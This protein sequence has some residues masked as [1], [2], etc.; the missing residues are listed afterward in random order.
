MTLKSL[1][2]TTRLS[3]RELSEALVCLTAEGQNLLTLIH[4]GE[5]EKRNSNRKTKAKRESTTIPA[6]GRCENG[7]L[8]PVKRF[9][10]NAEFVL[11]EQF[12]RELESSESRSV[13]FGDVRV[14]GMNSRE[15]SVRSKD[16]KEVLERRRGII[17]AAIIKILKREKK[18]S[19]DSI[20]S[21]VSGG[22]QKGA[23]FP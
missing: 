22:G 1:H 16:I 21:M 15:S 20:A 5:H 3:Y 9:R 12:V 4:T 13:R 6:W 8:V 18:K 10:R 7:K 11:N 19:L 17:D 2:E 23:L 14:V